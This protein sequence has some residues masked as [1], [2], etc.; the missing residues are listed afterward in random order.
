VEGWKVSSFST[1]SLSHDLS[2]LFV[3]LRSYTQEIPTRFKKD[4]VRAASTEE[5]SIIEMTGLQR[6]L[7]NIGASHT[8]SA[9]E[10]QSIFAEVG[11]KD[12]RI[13]AHTMVQLL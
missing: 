12:G 13:P 7:A 6:V 3:Y 10:L 11:N 5:N 1:H 8:L 2:F 4:I 9:Y